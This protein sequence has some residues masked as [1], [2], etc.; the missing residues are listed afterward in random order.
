MYVLYIIW[1]AFETILNFW[2]NEKA[3]SYVLLIWAIHYSMDHVLHSRSTY[4]LLQCYAKRHF[5]FHDKF[6]RFST[7]LLSTKE[8]CRGKRAPHQQ[9]INLKY[10]CALENKIYIFKLA[11]WAL[12]SSCSTGRLQ[13]SAGFSPNSTGALP[14]KKSIFSL[15][16]TW[17]VKSLFYP[18]WYRS[19][20]HC[21][22]QISNCQGN[23]HK[24]WWVPA[25]IPSR[26][27]E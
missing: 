14:G 19:G 12:H 3:N 5:V 4:L 2:F 6:P 17:L 8:I 11:A 20:L 26:G 18:G 7:P 10:E 1:R 23:W 9:C 25:S 16:P 21:Q 22:Y 13:A 15:Y 24:F 27:E